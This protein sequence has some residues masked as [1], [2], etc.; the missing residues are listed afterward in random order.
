MLYNVDKNNDDN[1]ILY[2]H[3]LSYLGKADT[4]IIILD[5]IIERNPENANAW[6]R[7]GEILGRAMNNMSEAENALRRSLHKS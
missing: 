6:A 3:S 7:K 2:S 5:K 4:A 1:L